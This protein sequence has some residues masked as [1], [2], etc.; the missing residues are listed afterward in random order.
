M[1]KI[2]A[3][4]NDSVPTSLGLLVLR[5]FF[6]LTMLWHHGL[7]KLEKF[8][9][10]SSGFPDPLGVGHKVSLALT[11]FAEV[12]AAALLAAGLLT[13]F[14]A[15]VLA[16]EMGVAFTQIHK[17]ALG[18]PMPGEFAFIYLGAYLTLLLAG[19]GKIS[20]DKVFFGKSKSGWG[21]KD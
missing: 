21:K 19:G 9:T 15:L 2:F 5:L 11:L 3:P 20:L 12:V 10:L 1:K 16:F 4:G 7:D 8:N 18:G 13:R 17:M 14:A 6:G